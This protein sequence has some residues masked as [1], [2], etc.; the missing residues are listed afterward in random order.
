M[1]AIA[2]G[3]VAVLYGITPAARCLRIT[4]NRRWSMSPK[5][6]RKAP[7]YLRRSTPRSP[8]SASSCG[9]VFASLVRSAPSPS[10]LAHSFPESPA[11]SA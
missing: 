5:R 8:L 2:C 9:L 10:S 1:I 4:G 3:V 6:S 7:A 11:S